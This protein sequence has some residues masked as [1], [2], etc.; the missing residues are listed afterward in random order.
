VEREDDSVI[1]S[2]VKG[3]E[4]TAHMRARASYAR[5]R[6]YLYIDVCSLLYGKRRAVERESDSVVC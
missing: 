1:Y 4:N 5:A 6:T 2:N 3:L